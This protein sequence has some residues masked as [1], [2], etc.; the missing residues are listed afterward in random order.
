MVQLLWGAQGL[1]HSSEYLKIAL[2][3]NQ[4]AL[5]VGRYL[6]LESVSERD[7]K[8]AKTQEQPRPPQRDEKSQEQQ[9]SAQSQPGGSPDA[10]KQAA[11]TRRRYWEQTCV[12]GAEGGRK[13]V[14]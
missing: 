11:D 13:G 7:L 1:S 9:D 5:F 2:P 14:V 3:H 12:G 4:A 6:G 10:H 8:T